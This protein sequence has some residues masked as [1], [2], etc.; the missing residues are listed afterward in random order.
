MG[1][2]FLTVRVVLW[3]QG[4]YSENYLI[5]YTVNT[6]PTLH[7]RPAFSFTNMQMSLKYGQKYCTVPSYL[8]RVVN[9]KML[10]G[11]Q[12]CGWIKGFEFFQVLFDHLLQKM[13]S[14]LGYYWRCKNIN[15]LYQI[16]IQ[17]PVT[18]VCR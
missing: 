9:H 1:V 5:L 15:N 17:L 13:C 4:M 14:L 10:F 11:N 3:C 18:V 7:I 6:V 2:L 8:S 16:C 12:L